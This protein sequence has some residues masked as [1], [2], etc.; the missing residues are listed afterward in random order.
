MVERP[1]EAP[2]KPGRARTRRNEPPKAPSVQVHAHRGG[3]HLRP[4]NTMMAFEH[5]VDLGAHFLEL[6]VR[7]CASGELVVFHDETLLRVGGVSARADSLP[8]ADLQQIDVGSHLDPEY[9]DARVPT[10]VELLETLRGQVRF[11]IEIKEDHAAGDGTADKLGQLIDRMDLYGDVI[12]SSFNPLSLYRVRKHCA[13]PVGLVFPF[14]SGPSLKLKIRHRLL[15]KPWTAPLLSAY[16]LHPKETMVTA[17]LIRK[18]HLRGLA[19]NTWTVN[20]PTRMRELAAM[21]VNG[22]ITDRP[23]LALEIVKELDPLARMS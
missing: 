12:I 20:D 1:R 2:R 18:A 10:L 6:D 14:S 7:T 16:A 19:V 8:L 11:N 17:E 13:A 21:R 15:R 9:A 3:A 22:L 4:E 5:A 23:D